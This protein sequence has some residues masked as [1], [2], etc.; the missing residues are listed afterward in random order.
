MEEFAFVW[1]LVHIKRD[2]E[3]SVDV[4]CLTVNQGRTMKLL[5]LA[6]LIVAVALEV[7]E[8]QEESKII[9]FL[10]LYLESR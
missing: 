9:D 1:S 10:I 6:S 4:K 8:G 7:T 3:D 5:L 2:A